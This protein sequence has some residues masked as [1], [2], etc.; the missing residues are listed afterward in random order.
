MGHPTVHSSKV[1]RY[2][3][4]F[5][6]LWLCLY[7]S[8]TIFV[9]NRWTF[10]FNLSAYGVATKLEMHIIVLAFCC[11]WTACLILTFTYKNLHAVLIYASRLVF[12]IFSKSG[13]LAIGWEIMFTSKSISHTFLQVFCLMII[14]RLSFA[15]SHPSYITFDGLYLSHILV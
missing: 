15:V 9:V 8:G 12:S 10:F 7:H 2:K 13:H 5:P 14:L 1:G 11:M 3:A 4:S 6:S